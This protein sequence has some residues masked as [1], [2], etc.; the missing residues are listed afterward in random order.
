LL[1]YTIAN[2]ASRQVWASAQTLPATTIRLQPPRQLSP[3]ERIGNRLPAQVNQSLAVPG[4][5][6]AIDVVGNEDIAQ[7]VEHVI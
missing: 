7:L 6:I 1:L 4:R 2:Y 3:S 5:V